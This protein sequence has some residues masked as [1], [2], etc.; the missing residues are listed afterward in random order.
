MNPKMP[1]AEGPQARPLFRRLAAVLA[2]LCV[3]LA[4]LFGWFIEGGKWVLVGLCL[5]VAFMMATVATT[6]RWPPPKR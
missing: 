3:I 1:S 4:G 6:G 5:F 2:V